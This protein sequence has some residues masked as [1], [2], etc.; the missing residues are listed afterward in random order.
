VHLDFGEMPLDDH[1]AS[2]SRM[3]IEA[4]TCKIVDE[5]EN[6]AYPMSVALGEVVGGVHQIIG[7]AGTMA[8]LFEVTEI[9]SL[10][11][12]NRSVRSAT[13]EGMAGEDGSCQSRLIDLMVALA[14]GGVGLIISSHA[15]VCRE[16]QAS[17]WQ[18][19]IY[20]D[21]L[22]P[23]LT[24]MTDGVHS[25]GGKIALQL[26]HAGCRA[27][28]HLTGEEPL[29]PSAAEN[30][31]GIACRE[32]TNAEIRYTVEAFA[33]GALRAQKSGFDGVQIHAAHGYLLSQFLSPYYNKRTDDYGGPVQNRSRIV[34]EVLQAIRRE[35]GDRF[36]VLIKMNSEDF[37]DNGL[38]IGEMVQVAGMLEKAGIDAIELSGGTGDSGKFVPVRPGKIGS[39]E[40]E[41]YYREAAKRYKEKVSV[42][43]VLVGGI[44]SYSVAERCIRTGLADYI[45]LSRPLIR[46]PDLINRW[47]SGDAGKSTCLSDNRC[48]KP[49][50]GG[51]GL[52]CY[53]ARKS[54]KRWPPAGQDSR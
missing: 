12:K 47:K 40:D 39:E 54:E 21:E 29:G 4:G 22:I 45:S 14:R 42:P 26:A 1:P 30:E 24:K 15:Y 27:A 11:L 8:E 51:E 32:M 38:S 17:P 52:Y 41:V 5:S 53:T 10:K 2:G 34:L 49:A 13:W 3:G 19:G 18:L 35:V 28:F 20:G 16:G 48:F 7:K 25:Y 50:R 37:V 23:N 9:N 31:N 36:P 6:E 43:L 33:K 44:R 46:E